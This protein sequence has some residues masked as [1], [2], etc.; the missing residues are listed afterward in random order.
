MEAPLTAL[1]HLFEPERKAIPAVP[2]DKTKTPGRGEG[3]E[4]A[5]PLQRTLTLQQKLSRLLCDTFVAFF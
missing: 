4:D 1:F 3:F 5:A 2:L